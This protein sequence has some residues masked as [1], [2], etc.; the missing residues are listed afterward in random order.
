MKA[1]VLAGGYPQI[2]LLNE[3]RS[4]G[5]STILAD[6]YESPVAKPYADVFYQESTLDVD[7]IRTIAEKEKVDFIITACTDQALLTMAKVS[8][9]LNLPCYIDYKTALKVT[10]KQYMKEVFRKNEIPTAKHATLTEFDEECISAMSYPLVVKPTDCNSSKGVK[11]VENLDELKTA[12]NEAIKMSRSRTVIIEEFI[13]GDE[14]SVDVYVKDGVAN[15]LAETISE[16]I[17]GNDKFIIYRALYPVLMTE[18][19]RHQIQVIAQQIADAFELKNS[20]MLI[21]MLYDGEKVY[22]IEFSA[23]TGGGVKYKLI[24]RISGFDVISAVVDL[25]LGIQPEVVVQE[26][27]TRYISNEFLYC[28]PGTF[29][30]VTGVEEL[31]NTGI[32][33]DFFLFK[34]QG[35]N[36]TQIENSGD[37]VA[38]VT[39][40]GDTIAELKQKHKYAVE[41]IQVMDTFG[42]NIM[43]RDLLT[44]IDYYDKK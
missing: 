37:R 4:R 42:N 16:K 21:Q 15:V 5:I 41:M 22:V 44:D 39:I 20:P 3:L 17:Q 18:D 35:A 1:L 33:S 38:G 27:E 9:E 10:N 36:I 14:V 12:F 19:A 23:R 7:A 26:P 29:D 30:Y 32:I 34:W 31:I 13:S 24:R 2:A 8:E 11:K 40:Q 43:R 25:T 28:S 6:Y